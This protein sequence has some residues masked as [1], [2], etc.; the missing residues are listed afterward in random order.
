MLSLA[1]LVLCG[2]DP[3]AEAGTDFRSLAPL[4]AAIATADRTTLFEGLPH[5]VWEKGG[6]AAELKAKKTVQTHGFPFY[7]EP[8][9]LKAEDAKALTALA[10]NPKSF[11]KWAGAKLCG[12]FHPDYLV[13]WAVGKEAYR[14]QVCFGCHEVKM[15]GPKAAVCVDMSDDGLHGL[16]KVLKPY[17]KDRPK[18]E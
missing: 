2:A 3:A 10:A 11:Q 7:A 12:G 9:P 13:E 15:F 18:P 16:E 5:P 8:L 14:M 6:L 4:A 1:L 17:R